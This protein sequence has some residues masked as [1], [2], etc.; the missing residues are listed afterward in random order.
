[1][2]FCT[3]GPGRGASGGRAEARGGWVRSVRG[4]R[5]PSGADR[6]G[7]GMGIT[8]RAWIPIPIDF[9]AHM[10][11]RE[12]RAESTGG[13]DPGRRPAQRGGGGGA[14]REAAVPAGGGS[15]GGMPAPARRQ[16]RSGR[17]RECGRRAGETGRSREC[18][19]SRRSAA[20]AGERRGVGP[21][22]GRRGRRG[23]AEGRAPGC[24][25]PGA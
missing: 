24:R 11:V 15:A 1:M 18:R 9:F 22:G 2:W 25:A 6:R 20:D 4:G 8:R 16:A 7:P 3:A 5:P 13:G 23:P 17:G 14:G 12:R 19:R 10:R 21:D